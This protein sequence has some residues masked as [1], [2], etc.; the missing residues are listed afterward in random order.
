MEY[1][2]VYILKCADNSYYVG[3]TDNIEKR[4]A[5]HNSM[6]CG[7]YTSTRLPVTL[8]Y[9]ERFSTR[10]EAFLAERRIKGWSR[11]KKEALINGDWEKI[12]KLSKKVFKSNK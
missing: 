3:Q 7:S 10:N 1:F 5:E 12:K 9:L 11:E 4:L 6:N 2:F 8:V